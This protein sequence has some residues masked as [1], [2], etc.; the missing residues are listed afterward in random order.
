M[1]LETASPSR[2]SD[3]GVRH[4]AESLYSGTLRELNLTNCQKLSDI[5]LLRLAPACPSLSHLSL[6]YCHH[7]SDTGVEL[8]CQLPL[9]FSLDLTGCSLTDQVMVVSNHYVLT[10]FSVDFI[11]FHADYVIIT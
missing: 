9:L 6:A 5:S 8:L 3:L 11:N 2:V 10:L 1:S 4:I 7:I